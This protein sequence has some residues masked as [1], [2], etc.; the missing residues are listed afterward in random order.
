MP[1]SPGFDNPVFGIDVRVQAWLPMQLQPAGL[2][3]R[4]SEAMVLA[5]LKP[6]VSL[7]QARH[8]MA[9]VNARLRQQ[10]PD[11]YENAVGVVVAMAERLALGAQPGNVVRL[12][13]GDGLR[14]AGVGIAL[15]LPAAARCPRDARRASIPRA[16]SR[17][18]DSAQP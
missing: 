12:V 14:Q 9:A 17:R 5:R 15:G 4:V 7:E 8:D 11:G 10:Y 1:P 2:D 3:R 16:L 18:S 6:G 13:V